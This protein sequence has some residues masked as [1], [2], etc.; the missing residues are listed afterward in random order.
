M[1]EGIQREFILHVPESANKDSPLVFVIHGYSSSAEEI[2][3]YSGMNKIA[4][5]EGFIA[6]Y[7]QGTIDQRGIRFFNVGFQ[8]HRDSTIDDVSFIRELV[9]HVRDTYQLSEKNIFATGMSN[10]GDM[11][12]LLACTSSDLFKAVAPVAGVMMKKTLDNCNPKKPIP[13]FEIHG[14]NDKISLFEG[15]IENKGGWGSYY[16]LPETIQF[17]ADKHNLDR[18]E[19]IQI[20]SK[21][22]G[23]QNDIIFERYWSEDNINE[24]CLYK[25]VDAGHIWPG[26]RIRWWQNPL[27]WYYMGSGNDCLLY[28]SPSPRD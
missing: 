4:D 18:S 26:F 7:P 10:G 16:G 14:T 12:Y 23:D 15:D 22:D 13:V 17:W 1:H 3:Q 9:I 19:F 27:L 5:R 8:F 2:Q 28:T 24:V 20:A 25:I 6:V 11:S 21:G